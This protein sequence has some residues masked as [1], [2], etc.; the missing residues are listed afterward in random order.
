MLD[1]RRFGQQRPDE[2]P[3]FQINTK[4]YSFE[5]AQHGRIGEED[6]LIFDNRVLGFSLRDKAWGYFT[7]EYIGDI[8]Y[9]ADAFRKLILPADQKNMIR[10]LVSAHNKGSLDFDDI[11][12]GKGQ[13]MIMLLHGTPGVG[14]TLTAGE[15]PSELLRGA[16]LTSL[17]ESVAD[18]VERPLYSITA[19]D[20]SDKLSVTEASLNNVF[21]LAAHWDAV[22]L[23]DEADV[24][25][26]QRTVSDSA[27]NAIVAGESP[28]RRALA[29]G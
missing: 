3:I 13:G 29:V 4:R 23:I 28:M 15:Y 14:K 1:A 19:A 16:T 25:L 10:A 9:N 21:D 8:Q 26:T 22:L 2:V 24:F 5:D 11:I 7:V 17:V 18:H 27:R 12:K 6:L 20:I